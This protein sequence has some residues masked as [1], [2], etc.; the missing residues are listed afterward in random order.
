MRPRRIGDTG[1]S[2]FP[3]DVMEMEMMKMMEIEMEMDDNEN[4]SSEWSLLS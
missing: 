4:G 3:E 2:D 1:I